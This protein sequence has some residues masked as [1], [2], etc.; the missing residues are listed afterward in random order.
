MHGHPLPLWTSPTP[1]VAPS[2]PGLT[3]TV[4]KGM[5]P[6]QQPVT[7]PDAV[8][9]E[10]ATM[11]E[12]RSIFGAV[13][14]PLDSPEP[15]VKLKLAAC[16]ALLLDRSYDVSLKRWGQAEQIYE[17]SRRVRA[18]TQRQIAAVAIRAEEQATKRAG[19][20]SAHVDAAVESARSTRQ[21]RQVALRAYGGNS[22]RRGPTVCRRARSVRRS[23]RTIARFS[24]RCSASGRCGGGGDWRYDPVLGAA[25]KGAT[26]SA[27][28]RH[29]RSDGL[30]C[31]TFVSRN[32]PP[33]M[34]ADAVIWYS[35]FL[36]RAVWRWPK[37]L[38]TSD[39]SR[40]FQSNTRMPRRHDD[41]H[42]RGCS[43]RPRGR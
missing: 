27:S 38:T 6:A 1:L 14:D 34:G 41:D 28:G 42:R 17:R 29:K 31:Q 33:K 30:T 26:S 18:W 15:I 4:T 11:R 19:R 10:I 3:E 2:D 8:M 40:P 5:G 24:M 12:E 20:R 37:G 35:S 7:F 32:K 22:P 9:A 13:F 23:P 25:T 16:L 39:A 36:Y 21:F 43:V